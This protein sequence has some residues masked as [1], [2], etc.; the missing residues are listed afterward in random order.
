MTRVLL[1]AA[2]LSVGCS[3]LQ[4]TDKLDAAHSAYEKA[5]KGPAAASS[6][7]DL[8]TAQKFLDL[9]DKGLET[10]DPKLV[11]DRATVAVLKLEAAEALGRT[12]AI[13]SE[14][15]KTLQEVSA[16][17]QQL[18]EDAQQKLALAQAELEKE[19]AARDSAELRL[20]ERRAVLA[21]ETQIQDLPEGT[22]I[23]LPGGQL[24]ARGQAELLPGGRDRLSRVAEFLKSASRAAYV[25][26]Q[27]PSRGSGSAALALSGKRAERVRAYLVSEGVTPGQI[28]AARA[29]ASAPVRPLQAS[30]EFASSGAVN[31]V[32]EPARVGTGGGGGGASPGRP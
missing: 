14:R 7:A 15:D 27:P 24:F 22:V 5:Q 8:A 1:V 31:I 16:T 28:R 6:P 26:A 12:H 2:A 11:D 4:R 9:A 32:L 10:G 21:R 20:A 30:P 3:H 23:S 13:A 18:L 25:E 17:K 29:D 19:K